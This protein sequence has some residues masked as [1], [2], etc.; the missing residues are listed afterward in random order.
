MVV[1]TAGLQARQALAGETVPLATHAPP[2]RQPDATELAHAF[3]VSLHVSVVQLRPSLQLR[4][5][6]VHVPAPLQVSTAVQKSPSSQLPPATV[7]E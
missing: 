1:E 4:V 2:I 5:V 3:V 7:G 6:P